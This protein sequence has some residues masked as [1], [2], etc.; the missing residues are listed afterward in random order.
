MKP[1]DVPKDAKVQYA[2]L[3]AKREKTKEGLDHTIKGIC[4]LDYRKDVDF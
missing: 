2:D 4:A 3:F 1:V